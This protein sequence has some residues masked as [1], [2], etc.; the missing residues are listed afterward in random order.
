[1]KTSKDAGE[2]ESDGGHFP[3]TLSK[4]GGGTAGLKGRVPGAISSGGP[5]WRNSW[6]YR[7]QKLC[8]RWL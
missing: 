2:Q 1:V 6:H 8:F 7:L 5:L 3:L 4:V